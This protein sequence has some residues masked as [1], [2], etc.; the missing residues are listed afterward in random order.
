MRA[1]LVLARP[2]WPSPS[3]SYIP[4]TATSPSLL[5][6]FSLLCFSWAGTEIVCCC[7]WDD[8]AS[9]HLLNTFPSQNSAMPAPNSHHPIPLFVL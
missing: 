4:A 5:S 8:S 9:Q 6:G 2:R 3:A 1:V 7:C